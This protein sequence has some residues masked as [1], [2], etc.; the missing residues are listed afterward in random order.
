MIE[1][2]PE[3]DQ[4]PQYTSGRGASEDVVEQRL[5][6][7]FA[8]FEEA[9]TGLQPLDQMLGVTDDGKIVLGPLMPDATIAGNGCWHKCDWRVNA[10]AAVMLIAQMKQE[11]DKANDG[12]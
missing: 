10:K 2:Q 8:E 4:A 12:L 5:V 11:I 9:N 1:P 6:R 7:L 3:T